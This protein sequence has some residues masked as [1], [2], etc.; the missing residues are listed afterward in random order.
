MSFIGSFAV[1]G[2]SGKVIKIHDVPRYK[3]PAWR[4]ETSWKI[5]DFLAYLYV[6]ISMYCY[7]NCILQSVQILGARGGDFRFSFEIKA[8]IKQH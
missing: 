4:K 6:V 1:S 8:V 3:H 7:V 2:S 5:D